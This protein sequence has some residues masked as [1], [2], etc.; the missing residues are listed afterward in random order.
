MPQSFVPAIVEVT[1]EGQL[2]VLQGHARE[3]NGSIVEDHPGAI[4]HIDEVTMRAM[5][6]R[7]NLSL[8]GRDL[9]VTRGTQDP[10]TRAQFDRLCAHVV[11]AF[12][13]L[14]ERYDQ[15]GRCVDEGSLTWDIW[16]ATGT[17]RVWADDCADKGAFGS[18]VDELRELVPARA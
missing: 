12:P 4:E 3:G 2:R 10:L 16:L 9:V 15:E 14:K 17:K 11:S 1:H 6:A 7:Q 5:L 18:L 8:E 13:R